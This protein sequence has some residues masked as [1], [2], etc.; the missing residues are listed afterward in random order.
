MSRTEKDKT[1]FYC[2]TFHEYQ[3]NKAIYI[4]VNWPLKAQESNMKYFYRLLH[5]LLNLTKFEI[6]INSFEYSKQS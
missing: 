3:P 1:C 4:H 5:P 2:D 6:C